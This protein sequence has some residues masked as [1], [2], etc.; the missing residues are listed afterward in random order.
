MYEF[1]VSNIK[2]MDDFKPSKFP[3]YCNSPCVVFQGDG[4]DHNPKLVDVKSLFLDMFQ[5]APSE[6]LNLTGLEHVVVLTAKGEKVAF[7]HY[8]ILLKK[9]GSK[10][11]RVVLEELGPRFDLELRRNRSAAPDVA[12]EAARVPKQQAASAK[13]GKNLERNAMGDTVGRVHMQAQSLDQL[14]TR[15]VKGL[16]RSRDAGEGDAAKRARGA[17]DESP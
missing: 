4:F 8:G 13:L 10:V 7:R 2:T 6:K 1:G 9:S 12:R 17:G 5:H 3:N 16:K 14:Q 15:K 11:P